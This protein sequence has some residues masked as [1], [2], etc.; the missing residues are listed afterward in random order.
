MHFYK[1]NTTF[2]LVPDHGRGVGDEW[3]DH[4]SGTAHSNETW[5]MVMGPDTKPLGEM[6]TKEQIFQ[7]QYATTIAALLGFN[8]QVPGKIIGEKIKNIILP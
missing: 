3:T 1:N 5:F 4:G 6:K 8:Y 2:F 7:T